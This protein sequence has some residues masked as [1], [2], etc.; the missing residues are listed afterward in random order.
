MSEVRNAVGIVGLGKIGSAV[1]KHILASG[2]PMIG[3]ARRPEALGDFVSQGGV[4]AGSLADLGR[5]AVVIS[6]VFDDEAVREVALGPTG[7]LQ[8]MPG[9]G[10]HV[11]METISPA[12]SRELHEVHAAQG[13]RYLS[14]PVFGR[15]DAAAKG[16]LAI[17]CSGAEASFR[18]VEPI[19]ATT[20]RARWIGPEP[21]QAMLVKLIGNHMVLTLGEL[22]GEAFT[23]LGAGGVSRAETKAAL[24]DT[25]MPSIF[26]GYAQRMV[27]APGG[28][29]PAASAI[30]RKDNAL[31]LQ[32]AQRLGV[33][34]P[35]ARFLASEVI[36]QA[37]A[38]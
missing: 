4:A 33:E 5:A 31:A 11:A 7:F 23:F 35:L 34:L 20:G 17:M 15:S 26:A 32:A 13:Q 8:A 38:G 14:A 18:T 36:G 10:V 21:E 22:L 24:L 27:D 29:G 6:V 30:G 2:R 25:L 3:W 16:D 12:L 19:L 37:V 1:A 9:G 28:P